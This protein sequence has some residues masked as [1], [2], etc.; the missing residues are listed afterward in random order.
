[1]YTGNVILKIVF[2][3]QAKNQNSTKPR[4]PTK[5][6][7]SKLLPSLIRVPQQLYKAIVPSSIH[8]LTHLLNL[9]IIHIPPSLPNNRAIN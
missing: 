4:K 9:P 6:T 8:Q 2:A 1:M 5:N 7:K 3:Q